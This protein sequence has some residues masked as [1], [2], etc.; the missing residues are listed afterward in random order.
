MSNIRIVLPSLSNWTE[1]HISAIYNAT[2]Q[3]DASNAID[4]F[5]LKHAVIVVNGKKIHRADFI[6]ELQSKKFLEVV[7]SVKFLGIV[8]VPA[9]E[10][11]P[12][13]VIGLL[14][15]FQFQITD[16]YCGH[17]LGWV[18]WNFLQHYH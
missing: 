8:E 1:S 15:L 3:A 5:L 17:H 18:S 16:D 7:A 4:N 2:S 12:V 6:K 11:N 14:F 10:G 13:E 9:N